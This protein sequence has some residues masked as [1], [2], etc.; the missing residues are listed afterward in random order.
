MYE[1]D[2]FVLGRFNIGTCW[3]SFGGSNMTI[4]TGSVTARRDDLLSC[5]LINRVI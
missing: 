3:Q 1:G 5:P 2:E 4:V